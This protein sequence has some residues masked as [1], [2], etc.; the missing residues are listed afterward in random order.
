MNVWT[1]S[2]THPFNPQHLVDAFMQSQDRGCKDRTQAVESVS[3]LLIGLGESSC[4]RCGATL[5]SRQTPNGS[6]VTE[7]RCIPICRLCS[8][9]EIYEPHAA[10]EIHGPKDAVL[11]GLLAPVCDW[12]VNPD[13]VAEGIVAYRK[14][15]GG[16]AGSAYC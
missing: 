6:R 8:E 1:F 13:R 11:V 10:G 16:L 4:Y 3:D 15:F 2:G 12:P 7:C 5:D 9:A 14:R